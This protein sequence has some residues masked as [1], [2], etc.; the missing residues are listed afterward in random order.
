MQTSPSK[1]SGGYIY[2]TPAGEQGFPNPSGP[3]N[4]LEGFLE[5]LASPPLRLPAGRGPASRSHWAPCR[6]SKDRSR[7][8]L[9]SSIK[10]DSQ[11][12]QSF[13]CSRKV[14]SKGEGVSRQL[15]GQNWGIPGCSG[16]SRE[17]QGVNGAFGAWP[18]CAEGTAG[19]RGAGPGTRSHCC[20]RERR[21]Q[22]GPGAGQGGGDQG[23]RVPHAVK[24]LRF[25][26]GRRVVKSDLSLRGF[27]SAD[28]QLHPERSAHHWLENVLVP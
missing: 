1:S 28:T 16:G 25:A 23:N 6:W 13:P 2:L 7:G 20:P 4:H 14:G 15:S 22:P 3:R 5:H 26:R 9:L 27:L 18:P 8:A 21:W 10:A 19:V 17:A 12:L 24:G 11:R